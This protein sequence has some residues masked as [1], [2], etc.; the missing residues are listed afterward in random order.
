MLEHRSIKKSGLRNFGLTAQKIELCSSEKEITQIKS[1]TWWLVDKE[2]FTGA[3][4]QEGRT[5]STESFR[6]IEV[7]CVKPMNKIS[8]LVRKTANDFSNSWRYYY[9]EKEEIETRVKYPKRTRFLQN[10]SISKFFAE[11]YKK[12]FRLETTFSMTFGAPG[13]TSKKEDDFRNS[14]SRSRIGRNLVSRRNRENNI[15]F[16]SIS[17]KLLQKKN[18][19]RILKTYS[20]RIKY[21]HYFSTKFSWVESLCAKIKTYFDKGSSRGLKRSRFSGHLR[22]KWEQL[23]DANQVI[24][25]RREESSF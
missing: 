18:R 17:E 22:K 13:S 7:F 21:T 25:Y 2:C 19:I 10:N 9:E 12:T 15:S 23:W 3:H 20:Y 8:Y 11:T 16:Q 24:S 6:P 4:K 5:T 14:M 1:T